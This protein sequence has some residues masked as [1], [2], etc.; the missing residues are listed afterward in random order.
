MD[1]WWWACSAHC[2]GEFRGRPVGDTR[3]LHSR[4]TVLRVGKLRC[5][6]ARSATVQ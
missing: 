6:V 1:E 5:A 3:E 2:V 4:P